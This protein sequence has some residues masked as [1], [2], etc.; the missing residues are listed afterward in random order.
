MVV[1]MPAEKATKD[2]LGRSARLRAHRT[3][4]GGIN[5][6]EVG[7]V[8]RK[9]QRILRCAVIAR[10]GKADA[11]RKRARELAPERQQLGHNG[12]AEGIN[13]AGMNRAIEQGKTGD[14]GNMSF[15][16]PL[17]NSINAA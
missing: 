14:H 1:D 11:H 3:G 9:D 10:I 2:G 4:Q 5:G 8:N 15:R 13:L 16:G 7:I 17:K 6:S 12:S